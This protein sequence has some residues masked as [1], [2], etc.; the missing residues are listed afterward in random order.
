MSMAIDQAEIDAL[1][2]A[3]DSLAAE[4]AEVPDDAHVAPPPPP[5]P[6]PPAAL[7]A[8]A[9]ANLERILRLQ[10]PVIVQL[11]T[12]QMTIASVRELSVGAII[13]FEKA[14]DDPLDLLVN[15]RMIGQ[16]RCI[17]VG[18]N[19]GLQ[20]TRICDQVQRICSMG[21]AGR[22]AAHRTRHDE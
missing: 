1:L 16:G 8:S 2:K 14:V 11:A 13:E 22:H 19:F 9:D 18:E 4:A 17:K 20:I 10:V 5:A 3:A 7:P 6:A 21:G 15:N 12:R